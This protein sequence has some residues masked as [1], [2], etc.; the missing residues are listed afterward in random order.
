V[1][2]ASAQASVPGWI[3]LALGLLALLTTLKP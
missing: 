2:M 3:T 1:S